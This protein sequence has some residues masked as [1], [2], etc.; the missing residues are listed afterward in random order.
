M[1]NTHRSGRRSDVFFQ[2]PLPLSLWIYIKTYT[3]TFEFLSFLNTVTT[4]MLG[5][6]F[7]EHKGPLILFG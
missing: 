5:T 7:V 1:A 6:V 4:Y 2:T 3:N